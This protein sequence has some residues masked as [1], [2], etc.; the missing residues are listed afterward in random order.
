MTPMHRENHLQSAGRWTDGRVDGQAGGRA[1]GRRWGRQ[2]DT[3]P[4]LSPV[5]TTD[6][7]IGHVTRFP[8][9]PPLCHSANSTSVPHTISTAPSH[10]HH[11]RTTKYTATPHFHHTTIAQYTPASNT[12]PSN[13]TLA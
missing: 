1:G 8:L 13:R 11:T 10:L 4:A 5:R 7:F 12:H 3:W 6:W 2:L 9:P